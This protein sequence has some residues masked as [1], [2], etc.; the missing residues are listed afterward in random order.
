M[1]PHIQYIYLA[2]AM[3]FTLAA[4]TCPFIGLKIL[5][6]W[7]ALSL[8]LV[9]SAYLLNAARIFR[10]QKD[11]TIPLAI[12]WVFIPF[13]LGVRLYNLM[14]RKR[15][16][17]PA[18]QKIDTHLFLGRR[19]VAT[20]VE[21]LKTRDIRAVLDVTAEFSALDNDFS[22]QG[23][24]Y[25]NIPILDHKPPTRSQLIQA[26]NWIHGHVK[27]EKAVMVHCA[28]GRGRSVLIMAAYLISREPGLTVGEALNRIHTI[29]TT[30]RLNPQQL[31]LLKTLCQNK[32]LVLTERAWLIANPAS[33]GGKWEKH[34][35]QILNA[36]SPYFKL[37]IRTTSEEESATRL[38]QM[39]LD[40]GAD[41]V[42]ACGGD[43]TIAQAAA[44]LVHTQTV[45][46]IVPFGT[47][48][49]LSHV[50]WGIRAK[51]DP[52]MSAC[53]NITQG[54]RTAIDTAVC[55][56]TVFLLVAGI[57]FEQ[58]MVAY[59]DRKEKDTQGQLAYIKGLLRAVNRNIPCRLR[60]QVDDQ[61]SREIETTSLIVA[62]A[63]PFSTLLAQGK[64]Q[65]DLHDGLLD[66][67][68]IDPDAIPAGPIFSLAELS[69]S[70]LELGYE[71]ESI[72]H[73]H[74]K[75]LKISNPDPLPY[76]LD[77]EEFSARELSISIAPAS[78]NILLPREGEY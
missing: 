33:G 28:L 31:K 61:P 72:R 8:W 60:V 43:G 36:L 77:G 23:I 9:A 54:R 78:L 34:R 44:A 63:A 38:S 14:A 29:R 53:E 39:A 5:L 49:A 35:E 11:G 26:V 51:I 12:R 32:D 52:V 3:L 70:A 47:T 76:V 21:V 58:Q 64:G 71:G 69:L 66:V 41:V 42:I 15:D 6:G 40:A 16:K 1:T 25:L 20:E 48:N 55:N 2:C 56:G 17:V 30:A 62:N 65:P 45:L 74:A 37:E 57:G 10:K 13:L 59:A 7:A 19:L 67:T 22:G 75:K 46:G 24:S 68:W 50:L 18:L 4:L 27:R 73:L